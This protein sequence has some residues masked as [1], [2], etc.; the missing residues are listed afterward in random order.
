MPGTT[1]GAA[2]KDP[3]CRGEGAQGKVRMS[4]RHRM[5][6]GVAPLLLRAALA[7]IF[8]WA[9]LGKVRAFDEVKGEDAAIL[10]NMGLLSKNSPK[11]TPGTPAAPLPPA[12]G[13]HGTPGS[14]PSKDSNVGAPSFGGGELLRVSQPGGSAP[15]GAT[16]GTV[17]TGQFTAEDF[18]DPVKVPR[19]D[20]L[21][22]SLHQAAFPKAK[23]GEPAPKPLWPPA[24]ATG[25]LPVI[26][27]YLVVAAEL[28]GGILVAIGLC[29]RLAAASI[30]GVMVGAMW[31][32]QFGPG[33]QAGTLRW[34]FLPDYPTYGMEWMM[35]LWQFTL[36]FAALAL[37]FTG[38]GYMALD[39]ALFGRRRN[40]DH[41]GE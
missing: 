4:T 19:A 13:S 15:S 22:L 34:G 9:G 35:L 12:D 27:A 23:E 14:A 2:R 33:W 7:V 25:R 5:A 38:P 8:I 16:P 28:G 17:P 21:A 36:C 40:D 6:L 30:A 20:L 3:E 31:L 1:P 39:H 10:A 24:L 37:F 18:P 29:T 26:F 41:D 32:T 11:V